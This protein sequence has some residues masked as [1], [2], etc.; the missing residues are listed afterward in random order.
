MLQQRTYRS[1]QHATWC[2]AHRDRCAV[3]YILQSLFSLLERHGFIKKVL[4]SLSSTM[5]YLFASGPIAAGGS[6]ERSIPSEDDCIADCGSNPGEFDT[7]TG[8]PQSS[9]K[10][11]F[12][13]NARSLIWNQRCNGFW[14]EFLPHSNEKPVVTGCAQPC[15]ACD[16]T[17]QPQCKLC[18][19]SNAMCISYSHYCVRDGYD[20]YGHSSDTSTLEFCP[21]CRRVVLWEACCIT[22]QTE[23]QTKSLHTHAR[24][25]CAH[26]Y[27]FGEILSQFTGICYM[28]LRNWRVCVID[29][30]AVAWLQ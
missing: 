4:G 14:Y 12:Q 20:G 10:Q 23:C 19:P 11:T 17:Q 8:A 25:E 18:L 7:S 30:A 16:L 2:H 13:A 5:R 1:H 22:M 26:S 28:Q 6:V 3:V 24:N 21:Q 27:L 15:D 9:V 29:C